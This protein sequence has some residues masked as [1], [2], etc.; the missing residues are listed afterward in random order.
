MKYQCPAKAAPSPLEP[1]TRSLGDYPHPEQPRGGGSGRPV[2]LPSAPGDGGGG[3]R[4]TELPGRGGG[5]RR[6]CGEN[7]SASGGT[8]SGTGVGRGRRGAGAAVCRALGAGGGPAA[9]SAP[10]S[11]SPSAGG[12]KFVPAVGAPLGVW[13]G[14]SWGIWAGSCPESPRGLTLGCPVGERDLGRGAVG[15]R[16]SGVE[17]GRERRGGVSVPPR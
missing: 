5:W 3:R 14:G 8:V 1:L 2:P 17:A 11:P 9:R 13:R 16:V 12:G 10:A 4:R 6:V 7:G 15:K